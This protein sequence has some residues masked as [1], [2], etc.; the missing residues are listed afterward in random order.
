MPGSGRK[1]YARV[2]LITA[3]FA[4]AD[5]PLV[6][7]FSNPAAVCELKRTLEENLITE[8]RR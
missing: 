5:L 1:R 6:T 7:V 8:K 2:A 3:Y 4:M